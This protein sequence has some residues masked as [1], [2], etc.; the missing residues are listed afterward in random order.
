MTNIATIL[1]V[2]FLVIIGFGFLIGLMRGL[3]KSLI[4]L[5]TILISVL[6]AIWVSG[7]LSNAV[8]KIDLSSL[9]LLKYE[10]QSA[11][12]IEEFLTLMMNVI[13]SLFG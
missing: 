12:T 10:G 5:I 9:D 8:V 4:R 3:N 7:S 2:V 1:N 13:I 6:V 11:S